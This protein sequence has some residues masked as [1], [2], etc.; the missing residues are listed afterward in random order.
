M[1]CFKRR[2][3]LVD[4]DSDARKLNVAEGEEELHTTDAIMQNA[5]NMDF[6]LNITDDSCSGQTFVSILIFK[7]IRLSF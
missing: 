1:L 4:L 7:H 5:A 3:T 6:T 2:V